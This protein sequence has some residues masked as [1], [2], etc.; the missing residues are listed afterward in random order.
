[1]SLRNLESVSSTGDSGRKEPNSIHRIGR[2]LK[3]LFIFSAGKVLDGRAE[4]FTSLLVNY[5]L[6]HE[7]GRDSGEPKYSI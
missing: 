7:A 3:D 4:S 1:M 6:D 5:I 2:S